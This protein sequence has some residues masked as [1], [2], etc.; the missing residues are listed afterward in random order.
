MTEGNDH[1]V[2]TTNKAHKRATHVLEELVSV[3]SADKVYSEPVV[4]GDRTIITAAEIRTGMG[5]G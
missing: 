1:A 3:A 2:K 5:F 4:A